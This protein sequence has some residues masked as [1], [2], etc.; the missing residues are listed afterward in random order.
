M[1]NAK[2]TRQELKNTE[3][4]FCSPRNDVMIVESEALAER[5]NSPAMI[6]IEQWIA[7]ERIFDRPWQTT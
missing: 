2:M 3:K 7:L 5:T 6:H 1:H 4:R